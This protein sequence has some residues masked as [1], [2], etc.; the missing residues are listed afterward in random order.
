LFFH[1]ASRSIL[2]YPPARVTGKE[3]S[4]SIHT[5]LRLGAFAL[6]SLALVACRPIQAPDAA[7]AIAPAGLAPIESGLAPVN[8]I[9]MYY[10]VY[11]E[12]EPVL[13]LH[14]GLGNA[15]YFTNQIPDRLSFDG[16]G[17]DG[18]DGLPRH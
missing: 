7:A 13:L 5:L 3:S 8:D 16:F 15:D 11:G 2:F 17:C 10:A 4:M 18:D 14:G 12:G 6:A 1:F 9:E